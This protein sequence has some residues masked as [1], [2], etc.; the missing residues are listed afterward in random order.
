L[1]E[2][3]VIGY[4]VCLSVAGELHILNVAVIPQ[5]QGN[6]YGAQLITS[7]FRLFPDYEV[8]YLEVREDN[9]PAIGLYQKFGFE[10]MYRRP[11]YYPNGKDAL[12]MIKFPPKRDGEQNGLV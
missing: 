12:V 9:R 3:A 2:Q 11:N 4:I 1:K 6:G 5:K 10:A 7:L 8:A